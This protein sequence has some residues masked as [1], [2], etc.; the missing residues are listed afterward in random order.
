MSLAQAQCGNWA[1]LLELRD[2]YLQG[3]HSRQ[4]KFGPH[5]ALLLHCSPAL[6][7]VSAACL[8]C[9]CCHHLQASSDYCQASSC[10]Q[11][12]AIVRR[13]TFRLISLLAHCHTLCC[14]QGRHYHQGNLG[15]LSALLLHCSLPHML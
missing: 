1:H 8:S 5:S 2:C 13:L 7:H 12:H 11:C 9:R 15:L 10:T 6:P 14:L 3:R 4:G